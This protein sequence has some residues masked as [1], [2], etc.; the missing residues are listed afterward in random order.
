M[1]SIFWGH[2]ASALCMSNPFLHGKHV[3]SGVDDQCSMLRAVIAALDDTTNSIKQVCT[4]YLTLLAVFKSSISGLIQDCLSRAN[5][6]AQILR[7]KEA[8]KTE[9]K[10]RLGIKP[11]P[12]NSLS[13]YRIM[14][15]HRTEYLVACA[16]LA[17]QGI[18]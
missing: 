14:Y 5:I 7:I 11:N 15:M 4:A 16:G 1:F 13:L 12:R 18:T 10:N 17:G 2:F 9:G 6:G 8:V 3:L